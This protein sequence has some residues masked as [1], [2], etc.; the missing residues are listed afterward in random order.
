[1]VHL[2]QPQRPFGALLTAMATPFE[3][4][5]ALDLDATRALAAHLLEQGHD[6]LVVNGTTGEAP[7]TSDSEKRLLVET[8]RAEVGPAVKLIAGIGTYNTA[9]SVRLAQEAAEAGADGL[10]AVAPYYS[11]PTQAGLVQHF[12]RLADATDLPVMIYDIPGRSAVHLEEATLRELAA[13]QRIVAVKDATGQAGAA[14]HKMV[15]TGL[16]YYAGDD[17]LGLAFIASG[18]AGIVSVVGHVAGGLWRELIEAV[19]A[20]RLARARGL[21][22]RLL[23]VITAVMGGGQGAVMVKAALEALGVIPRRTVRLPL[24]EASE[25]EAAHVRRAL[26]A[27]H[28]VAAHHPWSE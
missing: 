20:G 24:V 27:S 21:M 6:G 15:S 23:P 28:L 9:H 16:A 18:A 17:L 10:L 12:L 22:A 2:D 4:D 11:R 13:H 25:L 26:A 3:A 19:D 14:F 7:T 1:M 5:G 8:V